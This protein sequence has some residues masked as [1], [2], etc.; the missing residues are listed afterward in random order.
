MCS[1]R[2]SVACTDGSEIRAKLLLV[3]FFDI[4]IDG[5]MLPVLKVGTGGSSSHA[6]RRAALSI[7]IALQQRRH[8]SQHLGSPCHCSRKMKRRHGSPQVSTH[9][10]PPLKSKASLSVDEVDKVTSEHQTLRDCCG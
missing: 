6:T 7:N 4:E 9:A 1:S 5:D 3:L 2:T 10:V 8:P